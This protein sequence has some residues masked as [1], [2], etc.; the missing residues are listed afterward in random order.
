MQAPKSR[1]MVDV[2]QHRDGRL[3]LSYRGQALRHKRY[4]CSN[5]LS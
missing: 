2:A 1:A 5:H 3:E 4:A